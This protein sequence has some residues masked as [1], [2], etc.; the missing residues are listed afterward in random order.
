M[1]LCGLIFLN[2]MGLTFALELSI[3]KATSVKGAFWG[4][5]IQKNSCTSHVTQFPSNMTKCVN[6]N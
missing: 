3:G 2:I 4:V 5:F 1:G 6:R